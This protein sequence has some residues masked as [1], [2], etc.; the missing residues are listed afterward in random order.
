[1]LIPHCVLSHILD[2]SRHY[3]QTYPSLAWSVILELSVF[4]PKEVKAGFLG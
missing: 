4:T 2:A 1:M 3:G